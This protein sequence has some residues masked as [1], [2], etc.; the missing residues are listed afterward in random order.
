MFAFCRQ[1]VD[2]GASFLGKKIGQAG[3]L[4]WFGSMNVM[5]TIAVNRYI[6]IKMPMR[7]KDVSSAFLLT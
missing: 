2:T 7:Y 4:F 5:F 6:A 1:D 3:M